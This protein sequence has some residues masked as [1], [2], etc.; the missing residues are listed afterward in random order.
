[1]KALV[2]Y[3]HPCEESYNAA[4]RDRVVATLKRSGHDVRLLDLY[5][6]GFNP[7]MG[8]DERR[9]Y[10]DVSCN[11]EPVADQVDHIQWA[12]ILVFVYP[13]WWFGLPAMLKGWLDRVWIPHTTFSLPEGKGPL[14][15]EMTNVKKIVVVTTCG[16]T[17]LVSKFVGEPG[18]K[19]IMRGL[20]NLCCP[21]CKSLYLAH[22]KMDSSTPESR[23]RYLDK[24]ERR[25]SAL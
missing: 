19:T 9:C 12:D 23:T 11:E 6:I 10:H 18:R 20:K 14:K 22:Y 21:K 4:I 7:V 1:M 17:W 13:T 16:A 24:I 2:V 8:A 25:L 3:S 15:G 5:A